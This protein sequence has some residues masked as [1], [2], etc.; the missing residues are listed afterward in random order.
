MKGSAEIILTDVR[1]G[2]VT[3][4]HED[5][6]VTD[7]V[8][9]LIRMNPAGLNFS[10]IP[11][12]LPLCPN[13]IGGVLL[14]ADELEED[15]SKY[16][17]PTDYIP[18]G[19]ASN[20]Q[21]TT[22][23]P[24]RGSFNPNES[25]RTDNGYRLVFDFGTADAN[26]T[27]KSVALT[28]SD[29]GR[30]Y[31]GS[32]FTSDPSW[33]KS[34][35]AQYWDVDNS[36]GLDAQIESLAALDGTYIYG[37]RNVSA[38]QIEWNK[39][40]KH[41]SALKL[42]QGN[43]LDVSTLETTNIYTDRWYASS[44]YT[45]ANGEYSASY[46]RDQGFTEYFNNRSGSCW[47]GTRYYRWYWEAGTGEV[48]FCRIDGGEKSEWTM[49]Y[50]VA[51]A[52]ADTATIAG[53]YLYAWKS[54]G[55]KVYKMHLSNPT[56]ITAI[57]LPEGTGTATTRNAISSPFN[58]DG[59]L[60]VT[61]SYTVG[62]AYTDYAAL[63]FDTK[64]ERTYYGYSWSYA[65]NSSGYVGRLLRIGPYGLRRYRYSSG[66]YGW[67]LVVVAPYLATINNLASPV[68]KDV[69]HTMK[70]VYTLTEE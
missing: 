70:I 46:N 13:A 34:M 41:V 5:N 2:E 17:A 4:H 26:G 39:C 62:S 32:R 37:A 65:W 54:D 63:I 69:T 35:Y 45:N 67:N 57:S 49:S 14:F 64:M 9:D 11:W 66:D 29:G 61:W 21:D 28:S 30:A 23:D 24:K 40:V 31:F 33:Y 56:D 6:L 22:A 58:G 51:L 27:I 52:N 16:Y 36:L 43:G 68:V 1:T 18:L 44:G 12:G 53:S 10:G 47:D 15:A 20:S 3:R 38:T 60:Y 55:A 8:Q 7:A 59:P 42:G 25:Y 50:A 19:Y 48:R